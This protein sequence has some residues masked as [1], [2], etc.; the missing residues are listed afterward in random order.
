MKIN[1]H[2]ILDFNKTKQVDTQTIQCD[3]NSRF[4]RVSLRHNNSPI[5]LSDVRVC[6]MAVK[7]DGK[8][9]FNDCTVID[10]QNG[11]AEFEITKQMGIVVGE[12]ECQ[13]KLFGKEKL[14]SSNIFNLSVSKSLSPNSRD[15]KDQLNTL[16]NALGEVQDI[17]NRFNQTNIK[18][19]ENYEKV[20]NEMSN[21]K[22]KIGDRVNVEEFSQFVVNNDWSTAIVEAINSGVKTLIFDGGTYHVS[23]QGKDDEDRGYA[24]KISNLSNLTF[25]GYNDAVITFNYNDDEIPNIFSFHNCKNIDISGV[26]VMGVGKRVSSQPSTPLYTGSA[27]YFKDCENVNVTRC[28]TKNVMYHALA[29]NSSNV[30]VDKAFNYHDYYKNQPFQSSTIP[31]GFVQFHSCYGYQLT[32]STHYGG[33]RDGDVSV[34]GGGGEHAKIENN[35]LLGYG[36]ND[37]GKRTYNIAQGICNDQGAT[38]CMIRGNYV[39]GYYV[40][41]DMKADVRNCICENNIVENCK[42]S[43]S[44]RQGESQTVHQTQFNVIRGNKIIFNDNFED[45]G[46]LHNGMYHLVGINCEVRQGCWIENNELVHNLENGLNIQKPILGIYYSQE[47]VNHDYLYPSIIKGNNIVFTVGNIGTVLHAPGGSSMIHLRDVKCVSV[48]NNTLKGSYT[49]EYFGVK[50]QGTV[51]DIDILQ[52][53]F[54]VSGNTKLLYTESNTTINNLV[55]DINRVRQDLNDGVK[56]IIG[57]KETLKRIVT[58]SYTLTPSGQVVGMFL[59]NRGNY[60][61][62]KLVCCADWGGLRYLN[63]TYMVRK[64]ENSVELTKIDGSCSGYEVVA[65]NTD[66]GYNIRVITDVEVPNQSFYI[67]LLSCQ[68]TCGFNVMPN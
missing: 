42:I 19:D 54:W 43:I 55:S 34:F 41:I 5:D 33:C 12:V 10:A 40:G 35:R 22:I 44:D 28:W 13:I 57:E 38:S 37:K 15:S 1:N 29:F 62:I 18:I 16:V 11:I 20:N 36:Y 49:M 61:M 24:V 60:H 9:I 53:K 64:L 50:C 7:P 6:I 4:V 3:M 39:Y 47:Q 51:S 58:P 2:I 17:N 32:N 25:E 59:C 68:Y 26:K 21:V 48:T 67:E 52:N 23:M 30:I 45:N 46:Y 66:Y 27:F 31:F 56:E 65:D 63:A 14:L 8:E